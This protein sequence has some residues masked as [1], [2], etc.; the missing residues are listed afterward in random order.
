M[1]P[2]TLA[3]RN[4]VAFEKALQTGDVGEVQ[5]QSPRPA[6]FGG[7]VTV[8]VYFVSPENVD[9]HIFPAELHALCP[10]GETQVDPIAFYRASFIGGDRKAIAFYK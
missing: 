10:R 9:G 6:L 5:K 7:A 1:L 8:R 4:A 3:G 2:Q